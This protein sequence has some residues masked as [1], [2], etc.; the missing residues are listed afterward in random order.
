MSYFIEN[1]YILLT[2]IVFFV[3][4]V[5]SVVVSIFAKYADC[6]FFGIPHKLVKIP[7]LNLSEILTEIML[8]VGLGFI[9]PYILA[10]FSTRTSIPVA[11]VMG[12]LTIVSVVVALL[13]LYFNALKGRFT[14]RDGLKLVFI[15]ISISIAF[16]MAFHEGDRVMAGVIVIYTSSMFGFIVWPVLKRFFGIFFFGSYSDV[17]V[18]KIEEK[19]YFL[20]YPT[21]G[22][23]WVMMPFEIEKNM[24]SGYFL[25]KRGEFI[26]RDIEGLRLESG[27]AKLKPIDEKR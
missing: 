5:A 18:V 7:M 20:T 15:A 17:T 25:F 14:R 24:S 12:V 11:F 21:Q 23:K 9:F 16:F 10:R 13:V 26:I 19:R 27:T 8:P 6:Y 2:F 3:G 1:I 22:D 4:I